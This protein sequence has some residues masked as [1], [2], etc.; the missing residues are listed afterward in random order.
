MGD[1]DTHIGDRLA[2]SPV[3]TSAPCRLDMGGTLDISTF[4]YPLHHLNPCTFNLALDLRTQVRFH[5][6]H[7][8]LVRITSK[9]F[10]P[11]EYP[12]NEA[13]FD[14]PLGLM[15]AIANYFQATGL[16]IDIESNS[17]PRSALG[18]SSVAAVA[19]VAAFARRSGKKVFSR[20]LK[21]KIA[22]LAYKIEGSVAGVPCG[23]QD[24][25]A[26]AYGG[27]NAWYWSGDVSGPAFRKRVVVRKSRLKTL[28]QNIALA[29][30]GIPHDSK[31]INS[32]W[33]KGFVSGKHRSRWYEIVTCTNNF[34][35]ALHSN[36]IDGAVK[37]VNSELSIRRE[38]TPDVLDDM[39]E[40]LVESAG[41]NNCGARFTG[42][43]G[44]GCIWAIG[45]ADNIT[46]LK[47]IWE[48]DLKD[49]EEACLIDV[50]IDSK[51][52]LF[53]DC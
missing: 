47:R 53:H 11:A 27:V 23:L 33:V 44:G 35:D 50:N 22:L 2:S 10:E 49:R 32:R 7:N 24:Q 14:H 39:G 48:D 21:K 8:G 41:K 51:G 13:P 17:P 4:I 37:A 31:D 15:F 25:L 12:V 26:A 28:E 18:G 40:R 36:N 38:M 52:L 1:H 9:G 16:H 45:E 6:Y 3:V 43:G 29:Y 19:L 5:P 30:C 46:R 34:V 42:A 20:R